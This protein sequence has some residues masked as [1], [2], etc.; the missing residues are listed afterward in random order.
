MGEPVL[1]VEALEAGYDEIQVLWG[2]S[3]GV[4]LGGMTTLLGANGAGKTTSLRAITG[5]LKLFG[6]RVFFAGEDVTRLAPH[7]KAARGLILVPEGRQLYGTMSVEENL[8][9]GAFSARG[10]RR[11]AERL[12]QVYTLFPKLKERRHQKAGTFS[13]G[14]QQMLAIGRG[15]MSD[16][17]VLIIDELSLG[18][19]P[20]VVQ[21]LAGTLKALKE[22]GMTILLVEQNVHL[23]LALSDYAYVIAEGRPFIEGASAEVAEKPEIR[24]AYL[25]L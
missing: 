20:I 17:E 12:D 19:A 22:S 8:E 6:G 7:A 3:F 13:G 23:A 21:Q 18:L 4:R 11:F 25:G 1:R 24:Q 16:P 10:R 15:I 9:M 2:I 5:S 14:E